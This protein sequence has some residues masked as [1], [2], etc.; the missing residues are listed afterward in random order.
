[1]DALRRAKL[2]L[3]E[4]KSKATIVEPPKAKVSDVVTSD[5][6]SS[7]LDSD[8]LELKNYLASLKTTPVPNKKQDNTAKTPKYLKKD[9]DTIASPKKS[10]QQPN[11]DSKMTDIPVCKSNIDA[12]NIKPSYLKKITRKSRQETSESTNPKDKESIQSRNTVLL[13]QL[14]DILS[15]SGSDISSKIPKPKAIIPNSNVKPKYL[16]KAVY[17]SSQDERSSS[18][19]KIG[20]TPKPEINLPIKTVESVKSSE[21]SI[22]SDF[23][24]FLGFV[25]WA[26]TSQV[27]ASKAVLNNTSEFENS[28][29]SSVVVKNGIENAQLDSQSGLVS[30]S[31][32]KNRP[33]FGNVK[34]LS[35]AGLLDESE[36]DIPEEIEFS[37]TSDTPSL[38][39]ECEPILKNN[40]IVEKHQKIAE[41]GHA[42]QTVDEDL[43]R[44][45][46]QV[47]TSP[48]RSLEHVLHPTYPPI[49]PIVNHEIINNGSKSQRPPTQNKNGLNHPKGMDSKNIQQSNAIHNNQPHLP[50]YVPFYRPIDV[51]SKKKHMKSK[52]VQTIDSLTKQDPKKINN[53][54]PKQERYDRQEFNDQNSLCSES[55]QDGPIKQQWKS[56]N[57]QIIDDFVA[58]HLKVLQGYVQ[59]NKE[60]AETFKGTQKLYTTLE[61]TKAFINK[62]RKPVISHEEALL[63]VIKND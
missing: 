25:N 39:L 43:S 5:L 34:S 23:E 13:K 6:E 50:E 10:V 12:S 24:E 38:S 49:S 37:M 1:M 7:L 36:V 27:P 16:N 32:L 9:T 20:S 28:V 11:I 61:E 56:A 52:S 47:A 54:Q 17:E 22:G 21:D 3:N 4:R 26:D 42:N 62:N 45:M 18:E 57:R 8:E 41:V 15:E 46:T 35:S 60:M 55:S 53:D 48:S 2:L 30:S 29:V 31:F 58:E 33:S 19:S 44:K 14:S 51:L 59:M 40:A 63:D